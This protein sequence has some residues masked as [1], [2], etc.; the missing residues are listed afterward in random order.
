[1]RNQAIKD[2]VPAGRQSKAFHFPGP[3]CSHL[4]NERI[5]L[6]G[7]SSTSVLSDV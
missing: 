1:M 4:F 5:G 2:L 3:Q 6:D 7:S